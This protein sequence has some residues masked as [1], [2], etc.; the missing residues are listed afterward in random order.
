[1]LSVFEIAGWDQLAVFAAWT[2]AV[3]AL[4]KALF[5]SFPVAELQFRASRR[6][7]PRRARMQRLNWEITKRARWDDDVAR[8]SQH[9]A[10]IPLSE[11]EIATRQ[12]ELDALGRRTLPWRALQYLLHCW[13]CQT[14]W[15]AIG[16]F[17]LTRG[18]RDPLALVLSAA[19]YSGA[20]VVLS[21]WVS[22]GALAPAGQAPPTGQT[23]G[24]KN[25]GG[26]HGG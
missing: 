7:A 15:T 14:F 19:A 22:S 4:A 11:A 20:A 25:C 26:Q 21:A 18:V 8:R 13:A 12:H 6:D 2:L 3:C 16:V 1:M 5:G 17:A 23:G 24:C 10:S 9:A